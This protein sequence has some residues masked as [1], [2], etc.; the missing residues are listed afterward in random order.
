MCN[1]CRHETVRLPNPR[2]GA[3]LMARREN[4]LRDR[5]EAEHQSGDAQLTRCRK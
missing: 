3:D 4:W 2:G 5:W 1:R